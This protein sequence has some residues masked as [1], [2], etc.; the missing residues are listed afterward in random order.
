MLPLNNATRFPYDSINSAMQSLFV[1]PCLLAV[2]C[3]SPTR[4]ETVALW[5]PCN[6]PAMGISGP[7]QCVPGSE[8]IC[9]DDSKSFE[10]YTLNDLLTIY[11]P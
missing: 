10:T 9:K 8:C 3:S 5:D 4:R 6:Y 7:L 11:V 2:V 1:I